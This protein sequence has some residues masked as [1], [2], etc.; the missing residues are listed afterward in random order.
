[1]TEDADPSAPYP[2]KTRI[3][4]TEAARSFADV[5]N[6]AYYRGERFVFTKGGRP[7]AE[8]VPVEDGPRTR[9]SDLLHIL[10]S[11]PHL[12]REEAEALRLDLDTIRGSV[13]GS[14]GDPWER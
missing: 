4:V 9:A 5:V 13:G 2:R 10:G 3:T 14:G 6:R 7:V 12:D 8:L 1:M 11:M